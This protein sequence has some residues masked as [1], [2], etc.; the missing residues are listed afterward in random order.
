MSARH[1]LREIRSGVKDALNAPD[2]EF[3]RLNAGE[4][5]PSIAPERLI[6]TSLPQALQSIRSE[7]QLMGQMD[8]TLLFRRVVGLGIDDAVWG[9]G[10]AGIDPEDQFSPERAE[11]W[12]E[13]RPFSRRTTAGC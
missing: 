10:R 13:G 3:D 9:E 2:A 5:R 1:P 4:G 11:P 12:A 6:R 8:D 7:R